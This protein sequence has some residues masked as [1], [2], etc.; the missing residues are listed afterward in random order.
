MRPVESR[1]ERHYR[2]AI[3]E[4]LRQLDSGPLNLDSDSGEMMAWAV[5]THALDEA[6]RLPD[7]WADEEAQAA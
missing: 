2:E 5:L 4:A 1:V 6:D 3:E 7:P